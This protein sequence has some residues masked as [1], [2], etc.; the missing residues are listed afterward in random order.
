M[1]EIK[2]A[3]EENG[4]FCLEMTDRGERIGV[5]YMNVADETVELFSLNAPDVSLSDALF[6]ATLNAARAE[7]AKFAVSQ[8]TTVTHHMQMKGYAADLVDG[9]LEIDKFFSKFV[10]KG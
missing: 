2:C 1:V 8:D 7:G 9:Y 4:G 3:A 6:R 10:C 5:A